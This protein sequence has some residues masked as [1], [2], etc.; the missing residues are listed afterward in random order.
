MTATQN[1]LEKPLPLAKGEVD[2]L[3]L[4][5]SSKR[6]WCLLAMDGLG[7]G[8]ELRFKLAAHMAGALGVK[9]R[10][11]PLSHRQAAACAA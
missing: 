6:F 11:T 8:G 7:T 1:E 9:V 5:Q 2:P 4:S 10:V 3:G